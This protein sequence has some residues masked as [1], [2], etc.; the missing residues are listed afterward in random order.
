MSPSLPT[1]ALPTLNEVWQQSLD[2]QPDGDQQIVFQRLYELILKGNRQF[3]LTRITDPTEFW[4][5]HLWDSLRGVLNLK[6]SSAQ[7]IDIGTGAGFPGIPIAIVQPTWTVTLLDSTRKKMQFLEKLVETLALPN[8]QPLVERVEA[9][10]QH[11]SHRESY[12]IAF[13]RAVATASTCAEYSLPLLKPGGLAVLYRG[14]WTSAETESLES[15]VA[16]LGGTVE[17]V[18]EFRTPLTEG[19][20]SLLYL[21]KIKPTPSEFPRAIGI[22]AQK[23]LE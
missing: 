16:R 19:E 8:V 21:R 20:R 18:E 7:A 11:I 17:R 22:P 13:V 1:P 10:G 2:W 5:K 14:Q 12:D 9:I 15:V 3:N 6:L 23:P 4:E